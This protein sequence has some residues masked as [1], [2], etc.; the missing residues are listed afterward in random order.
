M[1][2]NFEQYEILLDSAS[3][4]AEACLDMEGGAFLLT[5]TGELIRDLVAAGCFRSAGLT[6]QK[7]CEA[8]NVDWVW[9]GYNELG[10]EE[11]SAWSNLFAG[12]LM[13]Y[14]MAAAK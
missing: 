3:E 4:V 12:A 9:V 13:D 2:N 6:L 11:K 10:P 14:I 1:E 8:V 5:W 7:L